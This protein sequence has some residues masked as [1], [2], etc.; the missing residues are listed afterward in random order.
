VAHQGIEGV[1]KRL[2]LSLL[3]EILAIC[4][5]DPSRAIPGWAGQGNFYSITRSGDEISIV[6]AEGDVPE[7]ENCEFGWRA[8]KVAGPL[9]FSLTGVLASLVGPLAGAEISVFAVSTYETDYLLVREPQLE[10]AI[11]ELA[12][13]GHL[14][15]GRE[16]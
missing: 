9:D 4:R 2:T 14:V 1:N 8:L 16:E 11:S 15:A 10:R 5:L 6:C 13:A 3:P 12:H 7:G